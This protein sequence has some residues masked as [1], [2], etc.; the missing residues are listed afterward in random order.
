MFY[1]YAHTK[2]DKTIF[3]IGKG[4]DNRAWDTY[5]RSTYWKRVVNKH[6][7]NVEILANLSLIH[8]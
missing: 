3:Y 5:N 4:K 7:F 8:I 2:P 6:G 1:T